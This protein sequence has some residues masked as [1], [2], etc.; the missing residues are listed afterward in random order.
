M[1][2]RTGGVWGGVGGEGAQ[3]EGEGGVGSK[4]RASSLAMN[5]SEPVRG[6]GGAEEGVEASGSC[7]RK[8]S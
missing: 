3:V 5:A 8:E 2:R 1:S 7:G 6:R 4:L